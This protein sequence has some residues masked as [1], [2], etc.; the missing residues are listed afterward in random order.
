MNQEKLDRYCQR[1]AEWYDAQPVYDG[2][3]DGPYDLAAWEFIKHPPT[4]GFNVQRATQDPYPSYFSMRRSVEST[5]ILFVY[6]GGEP[7]P[8]WS[9]QDNWLF[10]VEHDTLHLQHNLSFSCL[11]ELRVGLEQG[12]LHGA[13]ARR[14]IHTETIAQTCWYWY[15]VQNKGKE[16][17]HR[18]YATQKAVL[19]PEGW[20]GELAHILGKA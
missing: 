16:V 12:K 17:E 4:P 15:S 18:K 9:R 3:A 7:H 8:A 10:R 2:M 6:D 1:V 5:G 20:V 14:A 11:N 13:L 19:F